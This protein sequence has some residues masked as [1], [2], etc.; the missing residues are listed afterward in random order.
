MIL[1]E[2]EDNKV[3]PYQ[4]YPN[5]YDD[6]DGVAA[7]FGDF[8]DL[9]TK[10]SADGTENDEGDAESYCIDKDGEKTLKRGLIEGDVGENDKQHRSSSPDGD[11]SK[12]K[13]EKECAKDGVCIG[14]A[15]S[16]EDPADGRFIEVEEL[17]SHRDHKNAAN[18]PGN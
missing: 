17:K 5:T 16:I 2:S 6:V 4:N 1:D 18:D 11:R 3:D 12:R 13:P 9:L 15:E 10:S 8:S 14:Q 7:K